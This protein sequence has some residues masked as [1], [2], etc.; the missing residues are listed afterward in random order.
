MVI[1]PNL[2]ITFLVFGIELLLAIF[3]IW[4]SSR[5]ESEARKMRLEAFN[6]LKEV[7]NIIRLTEWKTDSIIGPAL[8]QL[9]AI[10]PSKTQEDLKGIEERLQ[11][12]TEKRILLLEERISSRSQIS[13]ASISTTLSEEAEREAVLN[14]VVKLENVLGLFVLIEALVKGKAPSSRFAEGYPGIS[15]RKTE[16]IQAII[17]E[18]TSRRLANYEPDEK[19]RFWI[20]PS[21][22]VLKFKKDILAVLGPEEFLSELL[23][24]DM[25]EEQR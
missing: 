12:E 16:E 8:K 2:A 1:D 21:S 7:Q 14:A 22:R 3:A 15:P 23:G 5:S 19:N 13:A 4:Q 24:R 10:H 6:T 25:F 11:N 17:G 20:Y 18:L 9:F